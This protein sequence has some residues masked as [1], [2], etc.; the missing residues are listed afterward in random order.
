MLNIDAMSRWIYPSLPVDGLHRVLWYQPHHATGYALG[1]SAM[2]VLV[3]ARAPEKARIFALSG[4]LLAFCL[5]LSTFSAI[6]LSAVAAVVASDRARAAARLASHPAGGD[7]RGGPL[8]WP[9]RRRCRWVTSIATPAAWC[10]CWS[11]R[12]R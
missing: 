10:A 1:L 7:C 12:W 4:M 2:L 9:R 11:I 8:G 5:M 6:M 3:Q